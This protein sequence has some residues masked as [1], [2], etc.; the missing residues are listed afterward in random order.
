MNGCCVRQG[1]RSGARWTIVA[2]FALAISLGCYGQVPDKVLCRTLLIR[3]PTAYGTAFT[4]DVDARQY[5]ITAKHV[6]AGIDNAMRVAI[7]VQKKSGWS[8]L[9]VIVYKCDD[10]VDVAVLIPAAQLTV[11][12]PLEPDSSGLGVGQDAYFIGFPYG[13]RFAPTGLVGKATVAQLERVADKKTGRILLDAYTNPGSSGSPLTYRTT[14]KNG[15]ALNVAGVVV[16]FQPDES[17]VLHKKEVRTDELTTDD[18]RRNRLV[19]ADGKWYRFEDSGDKVQ[20]NTG[21][22][23]AWDIGP[24]VDL[25]R[26]YPFGPKVS[27]DFH[28]E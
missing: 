16:A 9:Q 6:V 22:A 5:L 12:L 26:R 23:I 28:G 18:R 11:D 10:P 4:I 14:G 17:P 3:V 19:F 1:S 20:L 8:P 21:I 15:P 7:E 27:G 24:A 25:I 13:L 2:L